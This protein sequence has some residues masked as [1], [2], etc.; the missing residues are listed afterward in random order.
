VTVGIRDLNTDA[1][2]AKLSGDDYPSSLTSAPGEIV[3]RGPNV[4]R[5]YWNA[6]DATAEALDADGWY[7]TGDVGRFEDGYLR[8]T[9][10][11]KH[12]I[13]SKGGKNIY[14]GPIEERFTTNPLV[15]QIMVV[16]EGREYLTALVVPNAEALA[17]HARENG[18]DGTLEAD[19]VQQLFRTTF[20]TY[21]KGAAS[22]EKI[23]DFRLIEEPFSEENGLLTPTMKLKRRAVEARYADLVEAMYAG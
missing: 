13:V 1:L 6:P 19:A 18:S 10:R 16:G 21:S 9:D 14:P 11:I 23:R 2:V 5:G 17:A 4:M 22:H 20:R 8:I 3:A 15:E 12:M 7:H